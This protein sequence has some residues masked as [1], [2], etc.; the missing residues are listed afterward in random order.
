M[1]P[2]A[3]EALI[4]EA[5]RSPR[6]RTTLYG[7]VPAERRAA[8]F[9]APSVAPIVLTPAAREPYTAQAAARRLNARTSA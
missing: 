6:Q 7:E 5:G 1:R 8:S 9:G 3:M 4:R 2:E